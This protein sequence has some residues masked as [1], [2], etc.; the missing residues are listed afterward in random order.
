MRGLPILMLALAGCLYEEYEYGAYTVEVNVTS[1]VPLDRVDVMYGLPAGPQRT[2]PVTP[3][4]RERGEVGPEIASVIGSTFLSEELGGRTEA[5]FSFESPRPPTVLVIGYQRDGRGAYRVVAA[6]ET[7]RPP[8]NLRLTATGA[9][10]LEAWGDGERRCAR[11]ANGPHYYVGTG[12][13]DCDGLA[14]ADDCDDLAHCDLDAPTAAG[15]AG[16]ETARCEPCLDQTPGACALG[17]RAVCRDEGPGIAPTV[18]CDGDEACGVVT[19]LPESTCRSAFDDCAGEWPEIDPRQCLIF[20][21]AEG[22]AAL[23]SIQCALPAD[24]PFSEPIGGLLCAGGS[25][26]EA[27]L[28]FPACSDAQ[29]V[30]GDTPFEAATAVIVPPCTVRIT[31]T[32]SS[33]VYV[34][35]RGALVTFSAGG[36]STSARFQLVPDPGTCGT[37]GTCTAMPATSFCSR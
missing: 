32:P 34:R 7:A 27:A 13:T 14:T 37:T 30:I 28:P 29:V 1:T 10:G 6:S 36:T 19:C 21:W 8:F 18:A 26:V 17:T 9:E 15:R 2:A 16:C 35:A 23:D 33:G 3:G 5:H 4:R 24:P 31:L 22:V 25:T 11:V 20:R 12:D